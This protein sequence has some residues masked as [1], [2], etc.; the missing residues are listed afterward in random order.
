MQ[1]NTRSIIMLGALVCASSTFATLK[2]EPDSYVQDG[3]VVHLDGIRN[4]GAGLPHDPNAS[5][6]ANLADMNNPARITK[7][8]S[9]GWRNGVGYYFCW[10]SSASYAQLDYGTPAMTQATFEF[11]FEG[12]WDAQIA[13]SWGPCFVA[14]ANNNNISLGTAAN[15]LY[16]RSVDWTG[17]S[18][19]A[20]G[21]EISDWSWKQASFT[22]GAA[23]A[24]GLKS[25][26]QGIQNKS[27]NRPTAAENS[28]PVTSWM[29]G[30]RMGQTDSGRQLTGIMKA[31]RIYNRELS[32]SEV[33]QNAAIDAARFE[34]VMPVTN[35]VI[36]TAVAGAFGNEVPGV[37]AVDGSHVFSVP[38]FVTV[39]S[40]TYVSTGYT[41][42]TWE[43][44]AWSS[45]VTVA[46]FAV[47][48]SE[49]EKV[50]ITWLWVLAAGTLGA[51]I[52]A[53]S[54]DGLKVWYDGIHNIGRE[55][56]HANEGVWRELVANSPASM[57]TNANSHWT[58][59]GYYFA[60]GPNNERSYAYLRQLVSLGT[61]GTIEL[62]CETKATDQTASWA[63]YLTF[64]YTNTGWNASYENGMCIQVYGKGTFCV[65][66][67]MHG[68]AILKRFTPAPHTRTGTT[69][70]TRHRRG[71]ASMRRSWWMRKTTARISL[72]S[73]TQLSHARKRRRCRQPF[74]S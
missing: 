28:I 31:V 65:S 40:A 44:G 71:T 67:T 18:G 19:A 34:G 59:D 39:G 70:R 69:A 22:F 46:G 58:D 74:G 1:T 3:L 51:D 16:F 15:P 35:A 57:T 8:N 53:Y 2:Y 12:S 32:A 64:G 7:N 62:S 9:S 54:T 63:K 4:V 72:A 41:L 6:W 26:D 52:D 11:A 55:L 49:N 10:N 73:A 48:V 24:G 33:A 17:T 66:W 5:V 13:R 38:P 21:Q 61:V 36:A 50:R 20:T 56:P 27:A 25:Y 29:V 23:G 42:E 37:Y 14:G 47:T 45:P 30:S 68:Q 43:N 60:V